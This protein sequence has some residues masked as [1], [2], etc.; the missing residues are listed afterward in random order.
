[1]AWGRVKA[2]H[3]GPKRGMG[4]WGRKA[5]AKQASK[6]SRRREDHLAAVDLAIDRPAMPESEQSSQQL[7]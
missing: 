4:Y 1:M 3:A 5:D 7:Q 2:E 6:R